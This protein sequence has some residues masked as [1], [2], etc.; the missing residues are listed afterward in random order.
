MGASLRHLLP[1]LARVSGERF[2]YSSYLMADAKE[3]VY[4]REDE[5]EGGE[6]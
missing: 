5:E 6:G 4:R 1:I 3:I 2:V